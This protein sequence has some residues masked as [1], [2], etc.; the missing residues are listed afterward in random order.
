MK[1][2]KCNLRQNINVGNIPSNSII[3]VPSLFEGYGMVIAESLYR[4]DVFVAAS[5]RITDE[6]KEKCDLQIFSNHYTVEKRFKILEK[7]SLLKNFKEDKICKLKN[8]SDM[9]KEFVTF[10]L[11]LEKK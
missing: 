3:L 6:L 10:F 8:W 2:V 9:Q 4:G 5:D 1:S 11:S 7:Y